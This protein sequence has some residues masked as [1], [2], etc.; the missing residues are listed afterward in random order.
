MLSCG[1]LTSRAG[2]PTAVQPAGNH[3]WSFDRMKQVS[4]ASG[5]PERQH[6]LQ[7]DREVPDLAAAFCSSPG[8]R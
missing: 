1:Q 2:T 6:G 8:G 5:M 4:S 7:S 3:P